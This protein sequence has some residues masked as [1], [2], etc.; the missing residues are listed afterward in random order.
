MT[1]SG[2][3]A[4]RPPLKAP[5]VNSAGLGR[6]DRTGAPLEGASAPLVFN[7]AGKARLAPSLYR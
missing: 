1:Q 2:T 5:G 3:Y 7:W 6:E 4:Q